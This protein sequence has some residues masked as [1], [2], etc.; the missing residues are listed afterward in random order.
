M[1]RFFRKLG[2][3]VQRFYIVFLLILL[4]MPTAVLIMMSFNK[5]TESF[6]WTGFSFEK[7]KMLFENEDILEISLLD[8]RDVE[9]IE[10]KKYTKYF[11][12]DKIKD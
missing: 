12:Y 7:Y 3:F 2:S 5:N 6:E 8:R 1:R 9:R 10:E 11:D 4:Y